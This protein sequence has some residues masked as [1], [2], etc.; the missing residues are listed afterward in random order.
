MRNQYLN[1][2]DYADVDNY[3]GYEEPTNLQ[4]PPPQT[5][6]NTTPQTLVNTT[7]SNVSQYH[8]LKR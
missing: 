5:L 4:I 2:R 3:P 1:K 8:P 7:P 6:V